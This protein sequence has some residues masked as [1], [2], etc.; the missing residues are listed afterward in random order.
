M[1]HRVI[2]SLATNRFQAKNLCRARK[3]LEEVLADIQYTTELWTEPVGNCSRN[4]AYMNQLAQGT[5]ALDEQQLNEWLKL[6]E[7]SF[8]RT[9]QKR[10]LGI[11]PI[12]LDIL[13]YDGVRRHLRDWERQ[14]VKEL[15]GEF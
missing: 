10:R 8:G 2:L 1:G 11:V 3:Y 13:E 7:L 9:E 6:T 12:D 5:T 4:D 15:I 14:Y